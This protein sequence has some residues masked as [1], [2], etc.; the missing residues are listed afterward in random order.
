[1]AESLRKFS[2]SPRSVSDRRYWRG[3]KVAC[4]VVVETL[5]TGLSIGMLYEP[6]ILKYGTWDLKLLPPPPPRN[7]RLTLGHYQVNQP[8][9]R[10]FP[11]V[12]PL[13][14][15]QQRFAI[16]VSYPRY[17]IV[18]P[19]GKV[20]TFS[21]RFCRRGH[22]WAVTMP[23]GGLSHTEGIKGSPPSSQ[24]CRLCGIVEKNGSTSGF[25]SLHPR[26]FCSGLFNV[27]FD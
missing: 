19:A 16:A 25:W 24:Q 27:D 13:P 26:G 6:L 8:Q 18:L 20:T 23:G 17:Y 10:I 22:H 21:F 2:C 14:S 7:V 5:N 3:Q 9:R 12:C 1:M 4:L 15:A 11:L